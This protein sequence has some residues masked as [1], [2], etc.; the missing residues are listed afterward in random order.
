MYRN[1]AGLRQMTHVPGILKTLLFIA[2]PRPK[3]K[4]HKAQFGSLQQTARQPLMERAAQRFT[5]RARGCQ[6]A[7]VEPAPERQV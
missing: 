5:W 7:A 1:A 2:L 4:P 6:Y 3:Q